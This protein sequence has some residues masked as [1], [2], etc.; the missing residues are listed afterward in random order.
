MKEKYNDLSDLS[1]FEMS[2]G[3]KQNIES[4]DDLEIVREKTQGKI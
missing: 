1:D 4:S 3:K 2:M